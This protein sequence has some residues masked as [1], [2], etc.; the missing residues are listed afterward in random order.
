MERRDFIKLSLN[1]VLLLSLSGLVTKAEAGSISIKKSVIVNIML[2][3]GPDFRYIIVPV[4]IIDDTN[5]E[6]S[7]ADKFWK[8]RA[9]LWKHANTTDE[10][11]AGIFKDHY[12]KK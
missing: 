1:T 2:D 8:A 11:K 5:G 7:Y 6:T 10:L 4:L 3:G 12:I 9:S